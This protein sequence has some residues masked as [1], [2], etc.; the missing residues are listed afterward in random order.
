MKKYGIGIVCLALA[1]ALGGC[2]DDEVWVDPQLEVSEKVLTFDDVKTQTLAIKANG[3]WTAE[4]IK[5][6][7]EFI[8]SP[9]EGFGDGE[10]AITLSRTKAEAINGYLKIT[11]TDGTDEGLEV[12]EGIKL[13]VSKMD[14][15]VT[16]RSA[17]YSVS[18]N[19]TQQKFRVHAAGKWTATLSGDTTWCQLDRSEGTNE[20]YVT[21]SLKVGKKPTNK[22][23]ELII[24]PE[25]EPRVKYAVDLKGQDGKYKY[26]ECVTLNKACKG[27]GIDIVAVGTFFTEE[28]LQAGGRFEEACQVFKEFVFILEPYKSYQENFNVYAIP[29]FHEGNDVNLWGGVKDTVR[30]PFINLYPIKDVLNDQLKC[31]GLDEDK[32]AAIFKYA[33]ENSPVKSE[34]G[35]F[36]EMMV[37]NML[38]SDYMFYGKTTEVNHTAR[39]QKHGMAHA[40]VPIFYFKDNREGG[41]LLMGHELMGHG[42]AGFCEN[43]YSGSETVSEE[44]K[45][46]IETSQKELGVFLNVSLTTN[47]AEM[48]NRAWAEMLKMGYRCVDL[49]EGSQNMAFGIWR[50][51]TRSVMGSGNLNTS[52]CYYNPVQREVILRRIYKLAGMEDG[53]SFQTFLDYDL[54]NEEN[55]R[56]DKILEE[57]LR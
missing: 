32:L 44:G 2:K 41:M 18:L 11:Y 40:S 27:K 17:M 7:T 47:T 46:H 24:T 48:I 49:V 38:N 43:Y 13:K 10:V 1:F 39:N 12:A 45:K 4:A 16:P 14:M 26:G 29:Y 9:S 35:T 3:H 25:S 20:G 22:K 30:S 36:D 55:I 53:Y 6:S 33:Y 56:T 52:D 21:V 19:C 37:A 57:G 50:P 31:K 15:D 34:K 28:D 23:T 54:N 5:D 51:S 42:F 8:V